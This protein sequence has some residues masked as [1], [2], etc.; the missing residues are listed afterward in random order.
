MGAHVAFAVACHEEIK[1]C[2]K[3]IINSSISFRKVDKK[4]LLFDS[5]N[6]YIYETNQIGA[7]ILKECDGNKSIDEIINKICLVC[8]N[9]KQNI[10]KKDLYEYFREIENLDVIHW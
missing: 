3:P 5:I 9:V 1:M 6:G 2:R 10:V 8:P 7:T 4:Y